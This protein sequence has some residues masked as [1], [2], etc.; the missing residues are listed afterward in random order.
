MVREQVFMSVVEVDRLAVIRQV[1]GKR[2]LQRE[3]A[4]RLGV[5]VRQI[6]RLVRDYRERGAA[7]LVSV[8]RGR[9]PNNAI[10]D[11]VR[12][13]VMALV[14]KHYADFGPTLACEKLVE[15]H[16]RRL[17]AETLRHWMIAEDLWKAR[18]RRRAHAPGPPAAPA[19]RGA[20]ADRRL[21]ARL[22]RGPGAAVHADRVRR[23]RHEPAA[24]AALRARGDHRRVHARDARV[25]GHAWPSGGGVFGPAFHL[26]GQPRGPR[27][28]RHAFTRVL[29]TLDIEPVHAR[30][31]QATHGAR[32]PDASGPAGEGTSA[33][34]HDDMES[35]NAYLPE[36]MA[37]YNRRFAVAPR[38]PGDA[39]REV[40]HDACRAGP[41]P[42]PARH[43][44]ALGI[45][46]SAT[47]GASIRLYPRGR[48]HRLRG[49]GVTVCDAFGA[50]VTVLHKGARLDFRVL[51]EG[52]AP[53]TVDDGKSVGRTVDLG[54]GAPADATAVQAA[55]GPPLEPHGPNRRGGRRRAAGPGGP[56]TVGVSGPW[57]PFA[58]LSAS[59]ARTRRKN[60][61]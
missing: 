12:A 20:G 47:P 6:K 17:S 46:R 48:G 43:A 22:V 28:G 38:E 13:E 60:C 36:Y 11:G 26:P 39:H 51:A 33:P 31:P 1:V 16:G 21:A 14:R 32:Q 61:R 24:G 5:G 8:R 58:T 52:E 55:P 59:T 19:V 3:A 49:A 10:G 2:L 56:M 35:A 54:R 34:G 50:G 37:D 18:S 44:Q 29:K 25:P 45:S 27:G 4:E 9:R 23:R 41:H 53:V 7:G 15:D 40:P 57:T 30:S 42:L